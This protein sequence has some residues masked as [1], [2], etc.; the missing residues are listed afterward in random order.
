MLLAADS[1]LDDLGVEG[2]GDQ[3]DNES[4]LAHSLVEGLVIIDVEGNSLGVLESFAE[5]LGA[6]ESSASCNSGKEEPLD[7][8]TTLIL[9]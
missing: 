8:C 6:L 3:R 4:N 1:R 9:V 5:L 7:P 2:V